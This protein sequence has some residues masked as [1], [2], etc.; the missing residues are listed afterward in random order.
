MAPISAGPFWYDLD[1]SVPTVC[2]H[3]FRCSFV[4]RDNAHVIDQGADSDMDVFTVK[5]VLQKLDDVVTNGVLGIEAFC[6]SEQLSSVDSCLLDGETDPVSF[7]SAVSRLPRLTCLKVKPRWIGSLDAG[8][9]DPISVKK[10][11]TE[12]AM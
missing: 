4:T 10:A 5:S 3:Q 11:S 6:P 9:S 8:M 1:R 7:P 2:P 12:S